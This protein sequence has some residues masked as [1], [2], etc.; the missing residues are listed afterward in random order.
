MHSGHSSFAARK[1][2]I[3]PGEKQTSVPGRLSLEVRIQSDTLCRFATWRN[4]MAVAKPVANTLQARFL[5][6]A[7]QLNQTTIMK[8]L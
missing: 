5:Q 4:S 6:N 7:D 1:R 2:K 3:F 8:L